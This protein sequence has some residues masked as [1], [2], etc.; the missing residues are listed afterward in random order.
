MAHR[1]NQP[2]YVPLKAD[3]AEGLGFPS[4]AAALH[5]ADCRNPAGG[6]GCAEKERAPAQGAI[7]SVLLP[8]SLGG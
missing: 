6:A 4:L 7:E 3:R 5:T 1:V 8:D 2:D